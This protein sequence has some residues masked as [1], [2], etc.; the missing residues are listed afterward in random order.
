MT[1]NGLL[2]LIKDT[3][4]N[5]AQVHNYHF[6]DV[7]E[8]LQQGKV[9]H[10][11]VLCTL[12]N[13][14]FSVSQAVCT[15]SIYVMDW[16]ANDESNEQEVLSDTLSI[17]R[18]IYAELRNDSLAIDVD[19]APSLTPFVEAFEDFL[20]GFKMDIDIAFDMELD[21]CAVPTD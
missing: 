1:L 21:R 10:C 20:A 19:E 5:H 9:N 18:D 7:W 8:Y 15:F 13:V 3:A 16:V 6:G 2:K 4:E 14:R 17:I 11:S 12:N